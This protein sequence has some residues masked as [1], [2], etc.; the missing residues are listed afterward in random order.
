ML[1]KNHLDELLKRANES[2]QTDIRY[3]DWNRIIKWE[4]EDKNYFWSITKEGVSDSN[5]RKADIVLK[6]NADTV[7]RLAS[8][9]LP[10][11]IAIWATGDVIFEGS[12]SDAFRLGYIFLNDNR[13]RKV[14]FLTHCFLNTN[15]RFPGGCAYEG[16][17]TPLIKLLLESGVGIIQMPCPEYHCLGLEKYKYGELVQDELRNCFRNLALEVVEQV[18]DYLKFGFEIKGIIGMNPS[19]SC[20]VEITKGKGTMLGTDR[21]T[22]EKEDSGL[23][24]EEL[25]KLLA[26]R[27]MEE[28]KVFGVRRILPG[29]D[30]I[31]ER[32]NLINEKLK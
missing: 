16:A 15:T 28:V 26:E 17:T 27:N 29:E 3:K 31:E 4:V 1:V 10:F 2:R 13:K 14:V 12:F 23:F 21:D 8:K 30:G 6:C 24:I 22:S 20:G 5:S 32:L 11:F 7:K 9:D 19:P 18:K 25:T